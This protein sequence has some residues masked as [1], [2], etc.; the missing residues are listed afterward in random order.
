MSLSVYSYYFTLPIAL[1]S[2][3]SE[4]FRLESVQRT[5]KIKSIMLQ[6]SVLDTDAGAFRNYNDSIKPLDYRYVLTVGNNGILNSNKIGK[7]LTHTNGAGIGIITGDM[8][9]IFNSGQYLFDSF[10]ISESLD[11][12]FYFENYNTTKARTALTCVIL[13]VESRI[14]Y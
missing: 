14:Y 13:E 7:A 10:F 3:A 12:N 6:C 2:N 9:T 11:F 4:V 1:S 5:M 8:F